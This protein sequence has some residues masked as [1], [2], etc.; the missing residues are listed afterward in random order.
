MY[1]TLYSTCKSKSLIDNTKFTIFDNNVVKENYVICTT[2][3][4]SCNIDNSCIPPSSY[5]P[6]MQSPID[7]I[8]QNNP[9]ASPSDPKIWGPL[10][11][12]YLH[13]SSANYP[14][15]PT[16]QQVND[17]INFL[18]SLTITIPCKNCANHYQEYINKYKSQ[19]PEI[20]SD[21]NKLFNFLVD[22][23]NQVNKRNNKP[24]I[25]YEESKR[26]YSFK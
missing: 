17:M 26:M 7:T 9:Q 13:Y 24:L 23:H 12:K 5:T 2:P 3:V 15:K 18:C 10:I 8:V 1:S 11:W 25:S 16:Q 20:C 19:L 22:C 4:S 14:V 6:N 21:K